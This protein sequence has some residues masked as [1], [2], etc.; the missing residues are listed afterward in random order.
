MTDNATKTSAAEIQSFSP[1]DR[2]PLFF[3]VLIAV[4]LSARWIWIA[5]IGDYGWTY[6][7]GMRTRLGEIPYRDYICTLPP[8]TSYTIVPFIVFLKGNLW[9][10]SLHLYLWWFAT[11][12]VGLLIA[13]ALGL[14]PIA[15][16]AAMLLAVCLSLPSI[17]LGHAYS[18]AGTFFFGLT[19]LQ[20][21]KART[22]AAASPRH[23][24]LAGAFAGLGIFAKQNIGL[25]AGLLGLSVISYD[26]VIERNTR[27]LFRK[28]LLFGSGA[29]ITIVPL[30][31]FFAIHAG[32]EE[33]FQQM[34]S[35]GSAGKGGLLS[36]LF[37][38]VPLF[39]FT[40]ET[41]QRE[42]WSLAISGAL[43]VLFFGL[44]GYRMH[45]LQKRPTVPG[46]LQPTSSSWI[47]IYTAFGIIVL[48]AGASLFDLPSVRALFNQL[49]PKAIHE[50]HGFIAPLIF[51]AY[52]F[53]TALATICLLSPDQWRKKELFIPIIALP[54]ILWGHEL[55]CQGYLPF[56]AALVVPLALVLL[57]TTGLV[58]NTVPLACMAAMVFALGLAGSTQERFFA[59]CFKPVEQLPGNGKFFLLW[60]SH[61]FN[62]TV[63]EMEEKVAPVIR[64][65][66][67]LWLN[68]GGP[69]LAWGGKPVFSVAQL[70][71][72]T[73]NAR[74]EPEL[75]K[76]WQHEPP[77][78]IFVHN[79][80]P[81]HNSRL[82][83][84]EALAIWLPQQYVPV[85][86]SSLSEAVLWQL[87]AS[88][89]NA[90]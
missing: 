9:S 83:T 17:H 7:L 84:K 5:G 33:V 37:H 11:L 27:L 12:F 14:R 49:H 69:N 23:L 89:N 2:R 66:P 3:L 22:Q 61:E 32:A 56:G 64:G 19:L 42:L 86:K 75:V 81:T 65:K 88:T 21:I 72:D 52:S 68:S 51:V 87:R 1:P 15:Q 31:G 35:D 20:L 58:R 70:F 53:F 45:Q 13:R 26:C 67:T 30:F 80:R 39:F 46:A 34:F 90:Y 79:P 43:M 71:G 24:L 36:L 82:F 41:P 55:S 63:K 4:I 78:F 44:V 73:Y 77:E 74:S 48:L 54:L 18:Y 59:S 47:W 8:L 38:L 60:G 16:A 85:W 62:T 40:P 76:R 57:E 6:E 28:L 50:F 25:V 10:F 29:A